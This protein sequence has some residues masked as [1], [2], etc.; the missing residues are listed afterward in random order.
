MHGPVCVSFNTGYVGESAGETTVDTGKWS[1]LQ[2]MK[3]GTPGH[4]MLRAEFPGTLITLGKIPDPEDWER[5]SR[6][7]R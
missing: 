4:R 7:C 6:R 5:S 2:L 3:V 1:E